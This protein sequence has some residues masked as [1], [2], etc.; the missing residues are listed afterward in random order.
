MHKL[1]DLIDIADSTAISDQKLGLFYIPLEAL[2]FQ[3]RMFAETSKFVRFAGNEQWMR[4]MFVD[5]PQIQL[6]SASSKTNMCQVIKVQSA[7]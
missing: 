5:K 7:C 6:Q 3:Q 1:L 2:D 4:R